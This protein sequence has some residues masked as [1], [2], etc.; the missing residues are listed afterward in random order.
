MN[1]SQRWFLI[2]RKLAFLRT[3]VAKRVRLELTTDGRQITYFLVSLHA[4]GYAVHVVGSPMVFRDLLL[5]RR[6]TALPFII[7]GKARDTG[8]AMADTEGALERGNEPL[9]LL[10]DYDFFNPER[11][12]LRIPYFMHPVV[13][14]KG[15]HQ[16]ASPADDAPRPI[17]IGFFGTRDAE[18][19]RQRFYFPMLNREQ[20]LESFLTGF[21]ERIWKVNAPVNQWQTREIVVAIDGLGGDRSAKSFLPLP[22]YFDALRKCDFFLSPPGCCMPLSHN[23]IEGMAAGCIPIINCPDF[24]D[25]PLVDGKTCLAFE[26]LQD[27]AIVLQ[28]ALEMNEDSRKVMRHHVRKY[29]L[30][31]LVPESWFEGVLAMTKGKHLILVNAE[32]VS[33]RLRMP[34]V[35]FDTPTVDSTGL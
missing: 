18:F 35:S 13:Y 26:T 30:D 7:G 3:P 6:S 29:Y 20:I 17:R 5:L 19:Y 33:M 23:M 11:K 27:L 12:E 25:P 15:L 21:Q 2:R 9:K 10:L 8:V 4:L 14:A 22:E 16:I 28:R 31:H 24:F 34:N 32:E 1:L